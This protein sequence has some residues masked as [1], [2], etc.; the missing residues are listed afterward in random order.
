[1]ML[2]PEAIPINQCMPVAHIEMKVRNL[3][4]DYSEN[5]D[6]PQI[7]SYQPIASTSKVHPGEVPFLFMK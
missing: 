7:G 1:M 5:Q 2:L 4:W 6:A 3:S